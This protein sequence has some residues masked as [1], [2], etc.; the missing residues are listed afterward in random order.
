MR[1]TGSDPLPLSP[2]NDCDEIMEVSILKIPRDNP[3]DVCPLEKGILCGDPVAS[4]Q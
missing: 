4:S 3:R 1:A 2:E